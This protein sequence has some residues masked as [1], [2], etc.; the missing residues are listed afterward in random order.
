MIVIGEKINAAREPIA[1]AINTR[2]AE[3]IAQVAR[4][5]MR[6][7]ADYIDVNGADPD[8]R[9]EI[10]NVAW[11]M[12]VVQDA[13]DLPVSIDTV[14]GEAMASALRLA[15]RKPILNSIS[16]ETCRLAV[17]LP[18]LG[19]HD[20]MVIALLVGDTGPPDTTDQR[21]KNAAALIEKII[22]TGKKLDEIMID[23]GF[24]PLSVDHRSGVK[25]LEAIRA[26]RAEWGEVHI[27]AGVSNA[28]YGLPKRKYLNLALM[29]QAIEAGMDCGI[30]DPSEAGAMGLMRAAEA[31]A[32]RD[33][34][35]AK[36][37][38]A[39]REDRLT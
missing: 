35:C 29:V 5:Q 14:G 34:N 18:L 27:V 1:R 24:L 20:C 39:A 37:I 11:L 3:S 13:T 9:K 32:G 30:I 7:G 23:P 38:A 21:L 25:V 28:S 12:E 26:I 6:A 22:A 33:E 4:E 15:R 8:Q 17:M 10:D 2:D 31:M 36:Y 19:D 16:L